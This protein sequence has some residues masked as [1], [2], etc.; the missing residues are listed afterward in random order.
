MSESSTATFARSVQDLVFANRKERIVHMVLERQFA[1][2]TDNEVFT[3]DLQQESDGMSTTSVRTSHPIGR[4]KKIRVLPFTITSISTPPDLPGSLSLDDAF[5]RRIRMRI[6]ELSESFALPDG[7][8]KHQFVLKYQNTDRIS[9]SDSVKIVQSVTQRAWVGVCNIHFGN[10]ELILSATYFTPYEFEKYMVRFRG[11]EFS[12]QSRQTPTQF[13][14]SFPTQ[15]V[16]GVGIDQPIELRNLNFGAL[17]ETVTVSYA[18]PNIV[19]TFPSS[20]YVG[21]DTLKQSIH[22][23]G[24]VYVTGFTTTNPTADKVV[25]DYVNRTKGI[26]MRVDGGAGVARVLP[27]DAYFH[28]AS[29]IPESTTLVGTVTPTVTVMIEYRLFRIPIEVTYEVDDQERM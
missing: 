12:F 1:K 21:G 9:S 20:Y 24:V 17:T 2:T 14:I 15:F 18:A 13:T 27:R 29:D 28:S 11:N 7:R 4:I 25:I 23:D 10:P 5:G 8:C 6:H 3:W 19:F 22:N 16:Y 26:L